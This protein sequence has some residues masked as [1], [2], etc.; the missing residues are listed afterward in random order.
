MQQEI[1]YPDIFGQT[2]QGQKVID[3]FGNGTFNE[4][5]KS[6][7]ESFKIEDIEKYCL[8][9]KKGQPPYCCFEYIDEDSYGKTNVGINDL[10]EI[11]YHPT[12]CAKIIS[13]LLE[14]KTGEELK[15]ILF[16]I[17]MVLDDPYVA[18]EFIE[19][20]GIENILNITMNNHGN[21]QNYAM[22]LLRK[23]MG[24]NNG[25]DRIV[26]NEDLVELLYS[27]IDPTIPTSVSKQAIELVFVLC[28]FDGFFSFMCAAKNYAK[29]NS[30]KIFNN[31]IKMLE[32]DEIDVQLNALTLITTMLEAAPSVENKNQIIRDLK[33]QGIDNIIKKML[34]KCKVDDLKKKLKEVKTIFSV[35][36]PVGP[37]DYQTLYIEEKKKTTEMEEKITK[38]D[39]I[40]HDTLQELDLLKDEKNKM[41]KEYKEL[42]GK[43]DKEVSAAA[44]AQAK[45]DIMGS[46]GSQFTNNVDQLKIELRKYKRMYDSLKPN[47]LKLEY[48]C[49]DLKSKIK[50]L[51]TEITSIKKE[52]DSLK[53][54]LKLKQSLQTTSSD[55]PPPPPTFD[56]S[57][58]QVPSN[59]SNSSSLPLPPSIPTTSQQSS[60]SLPPPPPPGTQPIP[61]VPPPP[62]GVPGATGVPPP[63]PPPGMP[64]APPP[65]PPMGK[66]MPPP[67]GLAPA[68]TKL[69]KKAIKPAEKLRPLYWNRIVIDM[70]NDKSIWRE[71]KE[72]R[73]DEKEIIEMFKQKKNTTTHIGNNDENKSI[74]GN[75]K[76]KKEY[77]RLLDDKRY[78]QLGII[79]SRL[80]K[81]PVLNS[82]IKELNSNILNPDLLKTIK[83]SLLTSEEIA[84]FADANKNE[85]D[86]V[87]L[88]FYN[89]SSIHG[90]KE[91]LTSWEFIQTLPEK[92]EEYPEQLN[93]VE[94]GIKA[95][96]ESFAYKKFLGIVVSLGNYLNGGNQTRGQ[97][98]GFNIEFLLKLKDV[99]DNNGTS[100]LLEY[101]LK[102]MTRMEDLPE[103]LAPV[104]SAAIDLKGLLAGIRSV[105]KEM[106]GVKNMIAKIVDANDKAMKNLVSQLKTQETKVTE[107]LNRA[108]TLEEKT[109]EIIIWTTGNPSDANKMTT[110]D[111]FGLFK[112]FILTVESSIKKMKQPTESPKTLKIVNKSNI[113]TK[114]AD[115]EDPMAVLIAKIK[116]GGV[117]SQLKPIK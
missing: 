9:V 94:A 106:E 95:L 100:N 101:S 48:D 25:M 8:R 7:G 52:N 108:I 20:D 43:Y 81:E 45:L 59:D 56:M 110:E 3:N 35:K 72:V 89:I 98:D 2:I 91:R 21:I 41:E 71:I 107:L 74:G 60:S 31:I 104:K 24:Y 109:K 5:M 40:L 92:I 115:G 38:N 85:I 29:T 17:K 112:Q 4:I 67:P 12:I 111:F 39:Q 113:G 84:L 13:E 77:T 78:N 15:Q 58:L 28:A 79:K 70:N 55:L 83:D 69:N 93:K 10:I 46:K 96:K 97:A 64:G 44:S 66:G 87:E 88:F 23:L 6:L 103:Q 27:L 86:P 14:Q 90:V 65:P 63:P 33:E 1:K 62:P 114:V 117:K 99:K 61:G 37:I 54:N 82:A 26:K 49:V 30:I 57:T 11:V 53:E 73:V 105:N 16:K 102:Q 22:Q 116:A 50:E 18:S 51:M 47:E 19:Q 75:N 34:T 36:L 68:Q 32:I 80:P 42:K 76:N